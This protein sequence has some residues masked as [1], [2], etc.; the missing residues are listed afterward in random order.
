MWRK[1]T[2]PLKKTAT[3]KPSLQIARWKDGHFIGH[4]LA[5][6]ITSGDGTHLQDSTGF[7]AIEI[8][9]KAPKGEK[10]FQLC[11]ATSLWGETPL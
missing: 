1:W 11:K 3:K 10:L 6:S 7:S 5:S 8:Q 9:Q 2:K 4:F